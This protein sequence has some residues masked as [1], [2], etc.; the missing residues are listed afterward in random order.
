MAA[1]GRRLQRAEGDSATQ[2]IDDELVNVEFE[3]SEEVKVINS[4]DHMGLKEPLLRG[5]YAYGEQLFS[6]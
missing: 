2:Q 1:L 5:I 3:T 4:F 6:F